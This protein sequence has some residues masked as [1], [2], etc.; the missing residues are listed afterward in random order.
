M[1]IQNLAGQSIGQ[2]ELQELLGLGG[3]GAVY[4]AFQPSLKRSVA[5][6]ILTPALAQ[7]PGYLERFNREAETAAGLE[8]SHIVPIYDH[9]T[10]NGTSYVVMRYLTGGTLADRMRRQRD[11]GLPMPSLGEVAELLGQLSS[12]LDYAHKQGIVHRDIKPSNIM[13]DEHGNA[14]IVDFGI[15]KL[16][17]A[18]E[19]LTGTGVSMGTP[20]Y[21]APEQWTGDPIGPATDQ[22]ALGV[23]TYALCT[24]HPPFEGPTPYAL[25]HKHLNEKPIPPHYQRTDLPQTAALVL[26]RAL[27]KR[28]EERYPTVSDFSEAFRN[29]I[30]GATGEQT[31]FFTV[32]VQHEPSAIGPLTP[33]SQGSG[34]ALATTV[35]RIKPMWALAIALGV[36]AVLLGVAVILLLTN[37]PPPTDLAGEQ[38]NIALSA[39]ALAETRTALDALA[40]QQTQ[41]ALESQSVQETQIALNATHTAEIPDMAPQTEGEAL[42]LTATA[43]S[44]LDAETETAPATPTET[45]PP[46]APPTAT[47]T[48]P[49][50]STPIAVLSPEPTWTPIPPAEGAVDSALIAPDS[51]Q[52][53]AVPA[54]CRTAGIEPPSLTTNDEVVITWS[55]SASRYALLQDHIERAR[56]EVDLDQR[57]LLDWRDHIGQPE[58]R[59]QLWIVSWR[60]PVGRLAPGEHVI[61]YRLQWTEPVY[62]GTQLYGPSTEN[63][64]EDG[65]CVFYVV[66][67][68]TDAGS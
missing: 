45:L 57:P 55:W 47:F 26:E 64:E 20:A 54:G 43:L 14:Y 29:A 34:A 3:M 17:E 9:G 32:P 59:G 44:L 8:H 61:T 65:S 18:T 67:P 21:M 63:P 11:E 6:K 13:F 27:A 1:G 22:Y 58:R 31:G 56:Y 30:E 46:T 15:A 53:V 23:M 19:S 68:E 24:G 41:S 51:R 5:I 7:Q 40:F 66:E 49:P 50:S 42:L 12:A 62:D 25:M 60:Y 37:N 16:I 33:P 52:T 35:R 48:L 39:V 28:P 10:E 2:Y 4:R 36:L 38:T